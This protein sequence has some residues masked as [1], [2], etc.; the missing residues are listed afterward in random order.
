MNTHDTAAHDAQPSALPPGA[1]MFKGKLH[2]ADAKGRLVP[3]ESVKAKH[4]L[5]DE[6][7]RKV[8]GYAAPLS[9]E[10]ARFRQHTFEDVDGFV[11]LLEQEHGAR[12]GGAKG[13]MTF[14]S[15]DGL[16]RVQVAVADLVVFGPELQV[17]K[18][19]VDECLTDW[20]ADAAAEIRTLVTDAFN[21]DQ[22]GKVNR[23]AL[24]SLRRYD[25]KDERWLRAMDAIR[26]AERP[27]SSKRYV[28]IYQRAERNAAWEAV[29]IDMASV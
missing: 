18:G 8:L 27:I 20:A 21:V 24:L 16:L 7:V 14:T 26:E 4:L 11:A 19:L 29:S 15:Y 9:A 13:N 5:E 10:I 3:Y 25:F 6:L 28:R 2:L 22:A 1:I 12:K 17:A 23:A